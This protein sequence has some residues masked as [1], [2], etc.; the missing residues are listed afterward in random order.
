[1][2]EKRKKKNIKENEIKQL[3]YLLTISDRKMQ[4]SFNLLVILS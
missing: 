1:M 3:V 4:Y 2:K